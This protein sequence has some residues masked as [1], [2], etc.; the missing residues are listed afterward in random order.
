[1]NNK[2]LYFLLSPFGFF[3][4]FRCIIPEIWCINF[5][6]DYN[7][8][9]Q[10]YFLVFSH[11]IYLVLETILMILFFNK[12]S[13][14]IQKNRQNVSVNKN[15]SSLSYILILGLSILVYFSTIPLF[16][17]G[18]SDAIVSMGE[19]DKFSTWLVFGIIRII[20][21]ALL[22]FA[23]FENNNFKKLLFFLFIIFFSILDGKK[24]GVVFFF[25]SIIF[26]HYFFS[27]KEPKINLRLF[28]ISTIFILVSIV[29]AVIQ[30]NRTIGLDID[31]ESL[32]IGFNKIINLTYSSFSSYLKQMIKLN[33]LKYAEAYS[34]N[35]GIFG[36]VKYLL[37]SFT[38]LLF[39]IGIDQAIGPYLN[40]SLF[41][42]LF[43]NG[44][45][46][47]LFF[48]CIFVG[49]NMF[50]SILSFPLLILIFIFLY[51][52]SRKLLYSANNNLIDTAIHFN[53]IIF[54][55]TLLTDTLN[56]IR[57]LPFLLLLYLIKILSKIKLYR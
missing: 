18:G 22:F 32:T 48:E 30:F 4:L 36:T 5:L 33:G 2:I 52:R 57:S 19:T 16:E 34:N 12:I 13:L 21:T 14:I 56:A 40:Y 8:A 49:G 44:V 25:N 20:I 10:Y 26:T 15:Y 53:F 50:Y 28:L 46:P 27:S 35:L 9:T 41:G 37:N 54:Y 7:I 47:I 42:S 51:N 43:P 23:Y 55:L 1:L 17:D 3:L 45:N 38:K 11:L 29:Y 39:G 31:Y 24:G 6:I